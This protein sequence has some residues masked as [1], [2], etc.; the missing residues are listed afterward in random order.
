MIL[1]F[2]RIANYYISS[3]SFVFPPPVCSYAQYIAKYTA[4]VRRMTW[5]YHLLALKL[6]RLLRQYTLLALEWAMLESISYTGLIAG[7]SYPISLVITGYQFSYLCE[8]NSLHGRELY[9]RF[10]KV[11]PQDAGFVLLGGYASFFRVNYI[12]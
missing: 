11:I 8:V 1:I 10:K 6:F 4:F 9:S 3:Y 2:S 12:R 5:L 7:Q